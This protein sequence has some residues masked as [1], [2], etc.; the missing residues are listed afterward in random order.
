MAW[1]KMAVVSPLL[2]PLCLAMLNT[3]IPFVSP[4]S[5]T[6]LSVRAA[7]RMGSQCAGCRHQ[8]N[9]SAH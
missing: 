9:A 5:V 2:D 3:G 8:G 6:R 7:T 4:L 1:L